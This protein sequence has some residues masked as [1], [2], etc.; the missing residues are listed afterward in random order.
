MRRIPRRRLHQ[1]GIAP[2]V[3]SVEIPRN[4]RVN[5]VAKV[6]LK[7]VAAVIAEF[8]A[9]QVNIS[10]CSGNAVR[11]AVADS[12]AVNPCVG[13]IAGVIVVKLEAERLCVEVQALMLSAYS[14]LAVGFKM[15][16][17]RGALHFSARQYFK[18][19][20]KSLLHLLLHGLPYAGKSHAEGGMVAAAGGYNLMGKGVS[21]AEKV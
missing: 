16:Q 5:F 19:L 8:A 13:D 17:S 11:F 10:A 9:Y 21:A 4:Q 15:L 12:L 7:G 3:L 18:S 14:D 6:V 2:A 1:A 20:G